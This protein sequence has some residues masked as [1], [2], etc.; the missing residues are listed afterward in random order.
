MYYQKG[1]ALLVGAWLRS[2]L[3]SCLLVHG[4][5]KLFRVPAALCLYYEGIQSNF[6]T[7]KTESNTSALT[8]STD[9]SSLICL[10]SEIC[11]SKCNSS[12]CNMR[13]LVTEWAVHCISNTRW[14]FH[15]ECGCI[16]I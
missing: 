13:S 2:S 15:I 12:L 14:M 1:I 4:A 6:F 10:N 3:F 16:V 8:E 7:P 11:M 9:T 5:S